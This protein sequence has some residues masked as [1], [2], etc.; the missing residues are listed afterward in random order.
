MSWKENFHWEIS[1][2]AVSGHPDTRWRAFADLENWIFLGYHGH[3]FDTALVLLHTT[4]FWF[5]P[6]LEH[7]L[8]LLLYMAQLVYLFCWHLY[9]NSSVTA[10][11]LQGLHEYSAEAVGLSLISSEAE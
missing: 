8:L 1:Y 9:A 10:Y 3:G 4:N 5:T 7:S 2:S 11:C 6:V